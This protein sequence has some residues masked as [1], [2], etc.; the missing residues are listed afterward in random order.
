[1]GGRGHLSNE[2]SLEA[3][4]AILDRAQVTGRLPDRIVLLHRSQQCNHPDLVLE[5][6]G[7]DAR[8]PPRLTLAEQSQR[9]EWL[10]AGSTVSQPAG[11]LPIVFA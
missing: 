2:Q 1:M 8:I 6:F 10:Q 7:R 11:Q 9:T 3:V 4:K 5:L